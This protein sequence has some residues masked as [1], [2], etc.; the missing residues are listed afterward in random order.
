MTTALGT[1]AVRRRPMDGMRKTALV[2]GIF[3][4]ITFVSLPAVVLLHPVLYQ[5]GFILG[6]GSDTR[7]LFGCFL[8]FITALAGIGTAV[9]LFPVVKRQNE[10]VA[11]GF[12]AS[13]VLEGSILVIGT[14]SL[15]AVVGL[16]QNLG[17]MGTDHA[18]LVAVGQA[19]VHVRD[20]TFV[21]GDSFMPGVNALLLGYLMYRSR[22]VPRL[23]P[24][25]GSSV[26]RCSSFPQ[27]QPCSAAT[28]RSPHWRG[29]L[30]SSSPFGSCRSVSGSP[31]K[32]S[33][34]LQSSLRKQVPRRS[35][36]DR[37]I[38]RNSSLPLSAPPLSVPVRPGV[39]LPG[40]H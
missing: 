18:S 4:L 15:L 3:Y 7:V 27:L 29:L 19:L 31:S 11:L 6:S 38:R 1:N 28:T 8:Y 9:T 12:V 5:T 30:V 17:A 34:G 2:A 16:R 39:A 37:K 24:R 40:L 14:L 21:L 33:I 32:D 10:T 35:Q 22:L 23:I 36:S 13:R 20:W 25:S 26:L